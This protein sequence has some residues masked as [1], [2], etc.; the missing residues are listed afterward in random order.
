MQLIIPSSFF[1]Q[2]RSIVSAMS[3]SLHHSQN[4]RLQHVSFVLLTPFL[5]SE[6]THL[7]T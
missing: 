2:S 5:A 6:G 3:P 1:P 4:P 7:R